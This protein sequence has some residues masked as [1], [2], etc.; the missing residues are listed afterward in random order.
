MIPPMLVE[1]GKLLGKL[2]AWSYGVALPAILKQ[3]GSWALAFAAWVPGA[4]V[5]LIVE[6]GKLQVKL[7]AWFLMTA[8]PAIVGYFASLPGRISLAASGM[9]DG[10]KTAFRGVINWLIDKWNAFKL[11]IG[12]GTFFGKTIPS[13]TLE[14]PNLPHLAAGGIVPATPGGRLVR[15]A[16]GGQDEAIVPLP[17][18]GGKPALGGDT[19]NIYEAVSAMATAMQVSRRQAALGAV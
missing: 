8:I 7:G 5:R 3:L 12:G 19:F 17:K 4:A 13:I 1:L 14:T 11:V 16:E 10:I 9:W 15:V 6:L 18:G 2:G